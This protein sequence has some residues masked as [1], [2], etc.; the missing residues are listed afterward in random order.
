MATRTPGR[1]IIPS[2]P[3]ELLVLAGKVLAKHEADGAASPLNAQQDFSWKE[4]GPKIEPCLRNHTDAETAAKT[5]ERL[6]RDRDRDLPAIKAIVQNSAQ[7]LK[8]VYSKNP[9]VLGDY[10]FVID[11]TKQVKKE[12]PKN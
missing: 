1:I 9:K 5:A 7:L 4:E 11:D 12:K 2:N 6:Y 10:G 3:E 8:N